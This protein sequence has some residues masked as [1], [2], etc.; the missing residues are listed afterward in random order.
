MPFAPSNG[1]ALDLYGFME[2]M[3]VHFSENPRRAVATFSL[4]GERHVL[5]LNGPQSFLPLMSLLEDCWCIQVIDRNI[6]E[7]NQLEFGRFGVRIGDEDGPIAETL[8][9]SFEHS[10]GA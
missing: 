7:A 9:D 1:I 5:R 6:A 3:E 4:R 8:I 10:A 2:S